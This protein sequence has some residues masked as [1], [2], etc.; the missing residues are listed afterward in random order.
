[1]FDLIENWINYKKYASHVF[2]NTIIQTSDRG[3]ERGLSFVESGIRIRNN[4][5]I[6]PVSRFSDFHPLYFNKW[7]SKKEIIVPMLYKL[8]GNYIRKGEFFS[9]RK[10]D[11][12]IFDKNSKIEFYEIIR[13]LALIEF[14]KKHILVYFGRPDSIDEHHIGSFRLTPEEHKEFVVFSPDLIKNVQ[15]EELRLFFQQTGS[16]TNP[17]L[18]LEKFVKLFFRKTKKIDASTK[19]EEDYIKLFETNNVD[20]LHVYDFQ[21]YLYFNTD[22]KFE[23]EEMLNVGFT[24]ATGSGKTYFLLNVLTQVLL[25][26]DF[27]RLLYFDTQNSFEKELM[28]MLNPIYKSRMS[29][30]DKYYFKVTEDNLVLSEKDYA[31]VVSYLLEQLGY[32]NKESKV[33][34]LGAVDYEGDKEEFLEMLD[35]KIRKLEDDKTLLKTLPQIEDL[36]KIYQFAKKTKIGATTIFDDIEVNPKHITIFNF[37]NVYFYEACAYLYFKKFDEILYDKKAK[38]TYLFCDEFQKYTSSHMI[39]N[40]LL[41]LCKEKRQFGFRLYYTALEYNDVSFLYKFTQHIFNSS[42]TDAYIRNELAQFT[43]DEDMKK[44]PKNKNEKIVMNTYKRNVVRYNLKNP[45]FE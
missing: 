44:A 10:P 25:S 32:R 38:R 34:V 4:I 2:N 6:K 37:E 36:K 13:D 40:L 41:Q 18:I 12:T 1:M 22:D 43:E 17:N 24:G 31:N 28:P 8:F 27:K 45:I 26:N 39:K 23:W 3:A 30:H 14:N 35:N 29:E 42:L 9:R 33:K 21:K 5:M 19:E 20:K 16:Y 7:V 11:F 15:L